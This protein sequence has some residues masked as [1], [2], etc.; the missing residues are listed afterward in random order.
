VPNRLTVGILLAILVLATIIGVASGL[1]E[2][3]TPKIANRVSCSYLAHS[4][5]SALVD[6]CRRNSYAIGIRN[7]AIAALTGGLVLLIVARRRNTTQ[8][9]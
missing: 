6:S 3:N 9:Q 4:D 7:G 8:T 5:S 1:A 2:Y